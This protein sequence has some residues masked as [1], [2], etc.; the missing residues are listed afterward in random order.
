MDKKEAEKI[1]ASGKEATVLALLELATEV[2][3]LRKQID[4][5]EQT[6]TA[7]TDHPSTP[8]A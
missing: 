2:E 3:S 5:L 4:E 1:Y 6:L 7:R 8:S